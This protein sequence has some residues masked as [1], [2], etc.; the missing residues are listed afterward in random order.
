MSFV[1]RRGSSHY[2]NFQ[3]A[4]VLVHREL[5][6]YRD[7]SLIIPPDQARNMGSVPILPC[8]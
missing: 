1:V 3:R 6:K 8:P 5:G 4:K 7:T 2:M